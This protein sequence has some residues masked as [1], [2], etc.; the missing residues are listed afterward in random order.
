M[1]LVCVTM[2]SQQ[3]STKAILVGGVEESYRN[4]SDLNAVWMSEV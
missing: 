4:E 3:V 2:N 1:T